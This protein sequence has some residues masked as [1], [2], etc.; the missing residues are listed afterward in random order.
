VIVQYYL[1]FILRDRRIDEGMF[2]IEYSL[3]AD[4]PTHF[5]EWTVL[6]S[7]GAW[8]YRSESQ[9]Q[10]I[11]RLCEPDHEDILQ[12]EFRVR[13]VDR[14]EA[15]QLATA[16]KRNVSCHAVPSFLTA[17]NTNSDIPANRKVPCEK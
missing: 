13:K 17:P 12:F 11:V 1:T 15:L 5:L 3:A 4:L 16:V 6:V 9:A 10:E 14:H 7:A 8:I 2:I